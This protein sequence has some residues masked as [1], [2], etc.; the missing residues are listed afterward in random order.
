[1]TVNYLLQV[2]IFETKRLRNFYFLNKIETE[3]EIII[4]F[5]RPVLNITFFNV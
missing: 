4:T 5:P 1:M 3:T 2:K